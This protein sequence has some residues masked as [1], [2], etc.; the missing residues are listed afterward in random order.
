MLLTLIRAPH[1]GGKKLLLHFN[2]KF[3]EQ[4]TL[5][6]LARM[7]QPQKQTENALLFLPKITKKH[8]NP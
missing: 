8:P 4:N 7:Y 6:A 2:N 3:M 1:E 5:R